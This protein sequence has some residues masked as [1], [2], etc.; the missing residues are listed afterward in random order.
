M[1]NDAL[2]RTGP[3]LL[4]AFLGMGAWALFV[5]RA[6]PWPAPLAAGVV[7]GCL[8]AC[9]TLVM[10]GL[11]EAVVR[12]LDGWP[13]L[14][15]PPLACGLLSAALLTVLHTW[16]GTPEV[17]TTVALPVAV[18]TAYAASYA[19]ALIRARRSAKS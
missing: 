4:I 5:N 18:S 15:V 19:G 3:H 8:S 11:T 16:A 2:R 9:L 6:H 10:K 17:G 7:Q 1:S 12:R 13:A 14:V